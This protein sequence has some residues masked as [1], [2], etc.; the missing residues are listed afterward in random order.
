M[1]TIHISSRNHPG[2]LKL[3]CLITAFMLVGGFSFLLPG[4]PVRADG[5]GWPTATSTP[6]S[7]VAPAQMVIPAPDSA[8]VSPT[9][10][11]GALQSNPALDVQVQPTQALS[12]Q[13]DQGVLFEE[14]PAP[15]TESVQGDA[16]S[17]RTILIFGGGIL[18]VGAAVGFLVFRLRR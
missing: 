6:T 8:E 7:T 15:P 4:S 1:K 12:V 11:A 13:T 2:L 3:Y 5:G 16:S 10:P 9:S 17:L 18:L 14:V